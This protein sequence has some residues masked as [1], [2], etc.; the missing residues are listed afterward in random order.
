M[1]IWSENLSIGKLLSKMYGC[2]DYVQLKIW[3]WVTSV[4]NIFGV[5][6]YQNCRLVLWVDGVIEN[7]F[8]SINWVLFIWSVSSVKFSALVILRL[9]LIL[10]IGVCMFLLNPRRTPECD[11]IISC[12]SCKSNNIHAHYNLIFSMRC[13]NITCYNNVSCY[14]IIRCNNNSFHYIYGLTLIFTLPLTLALNLKILLL[15]WSVIMLRALIFVT[16]YYIIDCC[17]NNA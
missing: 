5:M 7:W 12:I 1:A 8:D 15:L 6:D 10:I 3:G 13:T 14:D 17:N 11:A 9:S 2:V 4:C 16:H